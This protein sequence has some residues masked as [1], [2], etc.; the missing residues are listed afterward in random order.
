MAGIMNIVSSQQGGIITDGLQLWLEPDQY[1]SYPG[2]GTSVY[3]LSPNRYT[4]TLVNGVTYSTARAPSFGFNGATNYRYIDTGQYLSSETFTLSSWFKS[5]TTSTYQ[6]L[7]SKETTVGYPWNY[8]FYLQLTQGFIVGD[9]GSSGPNSV[10][11]AGSTNLCNGVWHNAVFVRSVAL[12]TLYLYV[13]G[14]LVTST[15]DT[16]TGTMSNNQNCY[17]GISAYT[18]GGANP[19][20]SYP[21]NGQIGQSLIYNIALTATQVKQNFN[22]MRSVYGV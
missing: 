5:S 19:N 9:M 8:R 10:S 20:G 2:S 3:D 6:M 15:T 7:F 14:S 16:T 1:T 11:V 18:G 22:A 17:I 12:D 21:A 4:A 13:D